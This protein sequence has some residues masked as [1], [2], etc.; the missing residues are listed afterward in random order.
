MFPLC[1]GIGLIARSCE[2]RV[3]VGQFDNQIFRGWFGLVVNV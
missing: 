3:L 1:L 2:V